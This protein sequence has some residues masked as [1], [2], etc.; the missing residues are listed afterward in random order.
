MAPENILVSRLRLA[1]GHYTLCCRMDRVLE[2]DFMKCVV[3][4]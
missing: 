1:G 4:G 3:G 2:M